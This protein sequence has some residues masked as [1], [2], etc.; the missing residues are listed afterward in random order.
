[1]SLIAEFTVSGERIGGIEALS[2][3]PSVRLEVER[4]VT[5]GEGLVFFVWAVGGTAA[6]YDAMEAELGDDETVA[7]WLVV[8]DLGDQRL[9]QF[10]IDEREVVGLHR[11]DREVGASRLAMTGHVDGVDVRMRFPDREAMATYFDLI[12]EA[13][14]SVSLNGLYRGEDVPTDP[15]NVSAK[16]HEAMVT[17]LRRGYFE[18]PRA[19]SLDE[20]ADELDVSRQ[21][22]SE[23]L[24]RGTAALIRDAL[25]VEVGDELR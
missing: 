9:Y 25:E 10:E 1:M 22:A 7:D 4:S 3:A 17:A 18:I 2:A 13:G 5:E 24:R 12:R 14:Q 15:V 20:V 19:A 6:G 11:F 8:D 16:Q 23:R 21:A